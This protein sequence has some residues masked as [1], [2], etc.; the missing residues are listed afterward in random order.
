MYCYCCA[1]AVVGEK[2]RLIEQ[3]LAPAREE[4]DQNWLI[5]TLGETAVSWQCLRRWS[6][7]GLLD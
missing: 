3:A 4:Y 6:N 5:T 7:G 1:K 2:D